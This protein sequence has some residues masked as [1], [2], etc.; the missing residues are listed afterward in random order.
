MPSAPSQANAATVYDLWAAYDSTTP[1]DN[2]QAAFCP[3]ISKSF[4][5]LL[6]KYMSRRSVNEALPHLSSFSRMCKIRALIKGCSHAEHRSSAAGEQR[7][8]GMAPGQEE[9]APDLL[10]LPALPLAPQQPPPRTRGCPRCLGQWYYLLLFPSLD[11]WISFALSACSGLWKDL[12]HRR[13]CL[14][15][16]T[17]IY[18]KR[19]PGP[20]LSKGY[21]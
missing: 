7:A 11:L 21:R 8:R 19:C 12:L 6:V 20:Q 3:S 15:G 10:H 2:Q 16:K 5:V 9:G 17:H 13:G 4:G 1:L 18:S 14:S